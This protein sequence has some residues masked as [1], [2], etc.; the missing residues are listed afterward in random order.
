M[1]EYSRIQPTEKMQ[2][3]AKRHWDREKVRIA[4]GWAFG[5]GLVATI[6][7][8]GVNVSQD[9]GPDPNWAPVQIYEFNGKSL[10]CDVTN[11]AG[12]AVYDCS[13]GFELSGPSDLPV[14]RPGTFTPIEVPFTVGGVTGQRLCLEYSHN[15]YKDR[16][17]EDIG[18]VLNNTA[19]QM[20][21][22]SRG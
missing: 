19:G 1:S 15:G 12:G 4:A 8:M 13:F 2:E 18:N 14:I 10:E 3:T 17:C 22:S 7:G 5:F 11:D 20:P 6:V 21:A 9:E 16:T